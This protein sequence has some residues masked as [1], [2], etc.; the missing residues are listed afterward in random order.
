[1]SLYSAAKGD[2]LEGEVRDF[3]MTNKRSLGEFSLWLLFFPQTI[4]GKDMLPTVGAKCMCRVSNFR[5]P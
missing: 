5:P 2:T 3:T 4:L 1:M